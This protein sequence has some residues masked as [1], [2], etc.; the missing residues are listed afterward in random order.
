LFQNALPQCVPESLTIHNKSIS[1]QIETNGIMLECRGQSGQVIANHS[2]G[3]PLLNA[4]KGSKWE[5]EEVELIVKLQDEGLAWFDITKAF[6]EKW[7][8]RRS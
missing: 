1:G 3:E 4:G 8:G 2:S 6:E 5:V 7:P